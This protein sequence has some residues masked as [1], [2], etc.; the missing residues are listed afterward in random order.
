VQTFLN[1]LLS[2]LFGDH[3]RFS[4][5]HRLFNT[6]SLLNAIANTG[7][8]LNLL[9]FGNHRFLFL[10]QLVTGFLFLSFY[11]LARFRHAYRLLY[12]PF[13]LLI[14][15]FLWV[16][17]L[18]NAGSTGG[19]IYYFTPALVIAVILSEK[20]RTTIFAL[21]LFC[22]ATA[23]LLL[24][25]QNRPNWI[26]QYQSTN[27]RFFD[28]T[29]NLLFVQVF[30]GVLV[31]LLTKALN[32]E[33]QES[34]KLLLNILPASVARELKEKDR[35]SPVDYESASVLFTDFVG[36]TQTAENF[37]PQQLIE[38]LDACFRQFDVI[39]KKHN[40]EKIK[41]IG[42]SYMAVGGV[43]ARNRTHAGDCVRAAL[44]IER[45]INGLMH[46]KAAADQPSWRIRI[47]IHTGDLVAGVIGSEKFSYDVWGDTVNTASR[48]ESSG[49]AGR[50]NI[51]RATYEMVKDDFVC[52]YRGKIPAKN[53]GEVEMYFV[54]GLRSEGLS[55][56]RGIAPDHA[57]RIIPVVPQAVI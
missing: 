49:Q 30:T 10:L 7:G 38:E 45:F 19:T 28:I 13:V 43:P 25:E 46:K 15:G 34:D 50:I 5:E 29:G 4:L 39:A 14:L 54:N 2:I 51:S 52:E 33:R 23:A 11:Y 16:G 55:E 26:T 35:V 47:G 27:E 42:D 8:A 6:I 21:L 3:R 40:L 32:Q 37:T 24:L 22:L 12:W 20:V 56:T 53:K 36:F 57:E 41:T 9:A 18:G 31:I 44:E 17:A 1:H 48:L